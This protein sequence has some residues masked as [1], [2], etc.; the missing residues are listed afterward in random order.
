MGGTRGL[1]AVDGTTQEHLLQVIFQETE[2]QNAKLKFPIKEFCEQ[3][4][5]SRRLPPPPRP[6][7]KA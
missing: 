5:V 7:G 1:K 2:Q 3:L 6:S 4:N